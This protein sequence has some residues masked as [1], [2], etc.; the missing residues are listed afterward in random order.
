MVL[1]VLL[2]SGSHSLQ[3]RPK[4]IL[5]VRNYVIEMKLVNGMNNHKR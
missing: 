3:E 4:F 2:V 5:T 1:H